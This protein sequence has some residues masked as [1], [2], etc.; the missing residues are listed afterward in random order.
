MG[1]KQ[2]RSGSEAIA[3]ITAGEPRVI[4]GCIGEGFD[5]A[6]LDPLCLAMPSA[7]QGTL[8]QY[9]G[10]LHRLYAGKRVVPV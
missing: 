5:D 3:S 9:I 4:L 2:R 10:R 6:R 7:W 1:K 8:Q